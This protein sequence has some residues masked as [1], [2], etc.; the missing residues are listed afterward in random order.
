MCF[1]IFCRFFLK[2]SW[3]FSRKDPSSFPTS[4]FASRQPPFPFR[5]C[6]A[7]PALSYCPPSNHRPTSLPP[8]K[9]QQANLFH[10]PLFVCAKIPP[11]SP[12]SISSPSLF[13][14][15]R[16]AHCCMQSV[17]PIHCLQTA[18]E[19]FTKCMTKERPFYGPLTKS[20]RLT[21]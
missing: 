20:R 11:T 12:P 15:A 4:S 18:A 14:P 19:S 6:Q 3:Q 7:N 2:K 10:L 8:A 21:A 5:V 16:S 13:R 9:K 17:P 1:S